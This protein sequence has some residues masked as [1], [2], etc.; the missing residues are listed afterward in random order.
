[1]LETQH[2]QDASTLQDEITQDVTGQ[3]N[4]ESLAE[5]FSRLLSSGKAFVEAE[6]DKQKLRAALIGLAVRDIAILLSIAGV[7]L[8]GTLVAG[9]LGLVIALTPQMGALGATAAVVGGS[10]VIVFMLLLLARLRFRKLKRG[11]T[12]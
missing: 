11:V 3:E 4:E 6:A 10:F 2:P 12:P 8:F 1:M 9:M 5:T 7:L